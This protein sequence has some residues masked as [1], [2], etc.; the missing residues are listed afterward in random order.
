MTCWRVVIEKAVLVSDRS[1]STRPAWSTRSAHAG[2]MPHASVYSVSR[3][4]WLSAG[5]YSTRVLRSRCQAGS[6]SF[7]TNQC[8][9]RCSLMDP[10]CTL[11]LWM[12]SMVKHELAAESAQLARP[13]SLSAS[14]TTI[15][16]VKDMIITPQQIGAAF[17]PQVPLRIFWE[18]QVWH[19]HNDTAHESSKCGTSTTQ[20]RGQEY[21]VRGL[22]TYLKRSSRST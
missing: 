9:C 13:D 21:T 16:K 22:V 4:A 8:T 20:Q 17:V 3:T 1:K 10:G 6:V 14:F 19:Q 11:D 2:R 7:A 18:P 5:A 12:Q 15:A